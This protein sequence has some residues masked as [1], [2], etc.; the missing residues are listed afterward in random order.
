MKTIY[1]GDIIFVGAPF[2]ELIEVREIIK[3][4]A[5]ILYWSDKYPREVETRRCRMADAWVIFK[6]GQRLGSTNTPKER[7]NGR[8]SM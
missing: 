6:L 1:T 7:K 2:Y 5:Q 3:E 4:K 8:R